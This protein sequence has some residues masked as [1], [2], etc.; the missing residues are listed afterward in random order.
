VLECI[1]LLSTSLLFFR[2]L[3][4]PSMA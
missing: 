1:L 4:L 2:V 3:N